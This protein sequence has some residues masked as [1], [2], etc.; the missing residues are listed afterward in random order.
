MDVLVPIHLEGPLPELLA[1]AELDPLVAPHYLHLP[2]GQV[3]HGVL[4]KMH[5]V[6]LSVCDFTVLLV[7]CPPEI[8]SSVFTFA[9]AELSLNVSTNASPITCG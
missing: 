8:L 2:V 5:R 6:S 4:V 7:L 9:G 1:P 3:V